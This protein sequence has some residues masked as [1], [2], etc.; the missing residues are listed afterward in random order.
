MQLQNSLTLSS[1][2]HILK[3]HPNGYSM[4]PYSV[5][6]VLH[7]HCKVCAKRLFATDSAV[8]KPSTN[9]KS[10]HL[11]WLQKLLHMSGQ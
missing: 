8:C 7:Q 3:F 5:E 11:Y 4:T 2:E 10:M 9:S 6:A 1:E